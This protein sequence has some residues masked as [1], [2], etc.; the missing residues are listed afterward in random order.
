MNIALIFA[1]GVGQR[2]NNAGKPKQFI[3]LHNKP[4][5]VYTIEAFQQHDEID[6]IVIVCV[7]EWID[8]C[9]QLIDKY[10]LNKVKFIVPGGKTGQE[11]IYNGL[12]KASELFPDDSIVLI[13]DGVR[14]F[15]DKETISKNINTVKKYG[16]AITVTSVF[17]TITVTKNSEEIENILER[18][19]CY[20]A[21]APQSF[22]LKDLL[23]AH[24][25]SIKEDK[26]S[27]I[28]SASLMKHYGYTLHIVEGSRDNIKITTPTDFYIF[29][30]LVEAKENSQIFG[31]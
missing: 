11:S 17:E 12:V 8:Y 13:Q 20:V 14:P 3:E 25:K 15:I 7:K 27:F 1:G 21:K 31:F 19:N 16:S 23:N 9:A 5:L 6:S 4:I 18:N 29:R 22:L 26:N 10:N 2:M 30:A 28:D 24:K